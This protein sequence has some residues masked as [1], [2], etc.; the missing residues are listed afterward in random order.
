MFE[1]TKGALEAELAHYVVVHKNLCERVPLGDQIW[2]D[3][4]SGSPTDG[5]A[6]SIGHPVQISPPDDPKTVMFK[7]TDS[8]EKPG[9][10]Q[11]TAWRI[12]DGAW[13]A[14]PN[15]WVGPLGRVGV[16]KAWL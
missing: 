11:V 14:V 3:S 9:A 10:E 15:A 7:A 4:G 12:K 8:Y 16:L 5:A 1:A 13:V 6:W 2:K